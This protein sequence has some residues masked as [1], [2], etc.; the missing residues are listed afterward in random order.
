[1]NTLWIINFF[2]FIP[3]CLL[4][5]KYEFWYIENGLLNPEINILILCQFFFNCFFRTFVIVAVALESTFC[6]KSG[7]QIKD[8][9]V[10]VPRVLKEID[11]MKVMYTQ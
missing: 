9:D 8:T 5:A 10:S 2:Y 6:A 11:A 1:M 4:G 7:L 3:Q